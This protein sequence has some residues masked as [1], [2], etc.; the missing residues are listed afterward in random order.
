[1]SLQGYFRKGITMS[2]DV[3]FGIVQ[4]VEDMDYIYTGV[5]WP[6]YTEEDD[7]TNVQYTI[8]SGTPHRS[9][10]THGFYDWTRT[11]QSAR[12]ILALCKP[13]Y[14]NTQDME[15]RQVDTTLLELISQLMQEAR[16]PY[17]AD[18]AT[19]FAYWSRR[20]VAEFG[21]KAYIGFS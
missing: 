6:G 16:T 1:M 10:S 21:D 14:P 4:T 5:Y 13:Q 19:W 3:H 17:D 20:A 9:F 8:F 18:R 12:A 15:Y 2:V 11:N 7:G